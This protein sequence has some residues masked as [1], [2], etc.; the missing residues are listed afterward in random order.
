MLIE[1]TRL[2]D[3]ILA[4]RSQLPAHSTARD[5]IRI[6]LTC[7]ANAPAVNPTQPVHG[8]WEVLAHSVTGDLIVRCPGCGAV[9]TFDP[10]W[11]NGKLYCWR[12]GTCQEG[13][14]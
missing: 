10:T 4:E 7:I 12:C 13:T 11:I 1:Q 3:A 14:E 2:V 5:G 6:A 9:S 8:H